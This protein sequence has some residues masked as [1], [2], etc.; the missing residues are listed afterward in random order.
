[1]SDAQVTADIIDGERL[2]QKSQRSLM[3]SEDDGAWRPQKRQNSNCDNSKNKKGFSEAELLDASVGT[4]WF[5]EEH[6][7]TKFT[8]SWEAGSASYHHIVTSN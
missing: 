6:K 3:D 2:P 4:N 7:G 1:M 8:D 5:R